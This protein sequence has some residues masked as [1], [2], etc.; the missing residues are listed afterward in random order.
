MKSAGEN[1]QKIIE[2]YEKKHLNKLQ[3]D[4]KKIL[5]K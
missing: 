2:D 3:D 1:N 5:K 4:I